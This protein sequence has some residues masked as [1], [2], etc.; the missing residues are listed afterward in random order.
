MNAVICGFVFLSA[1]SFAVFF[2]DILKNAEPGKKKHKKSPIIIFSV[3]LLS[4][5][6][7]AIAVSLYYSDHLLSTA[8]QADINYAKIGPYG[9]L[10]GGIMNPVIALIGIIAASLAFYAQYRANQ[11]VQEQFT[12]QEKKDYIQNFEN[13][14]FKL[15]EFQNQIVQ[16][17]DMNIAIFNDGIVNEIITNN[18]LEGKK[19]LQFHENYFDENDNLVFTKLEVKSRDSFKFIF[20]LLDNLLSI[21]YQLLKLN[22]SGEINE[23]ESY[24][25]HFK[26]LTDNFEH[27]PI[28]YE[29]HS[30]NDFFCTIYALVFSKVNI[31]LGHYY[32]NLYRIFKIID[33]AS[34]EDDNRVDFKIK[35]QYASIVR[36]QLSDYEIY[37]LFY[38][39]I[40]DYG[41]SKFKKLIEK[42]SLLKI[43]PN[44]NESLE[45]H[46]YKNLY[47]KKAFST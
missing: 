4:L 34:F 28:V 42:Y 14:F 13:K 9:D 41:I 19:Y 29:E 16:D 7:L 44:D 6:S 15:I 43:I 21:S 45:F 18:P 17:I 3:L 40:S 11:Q 37:F 23:N 25:E 26:I 2:L 35:Y 31:D 8:D 20:E 1:I 30:V 12:K 5:C 38:N 32:R 22:E 33:E 10:I 36:S 46:V 47:H 39:G 24:L 27:K